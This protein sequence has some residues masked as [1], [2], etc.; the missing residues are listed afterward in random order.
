MALA[1]FFFNF[2]SSFFKSLLA[3]S[4]PSRQRADNELQRM[5]LVSKEKL[6][7]FQA[8]AERRYD[9]DERGRGEGDCQHSL[10][11]SEILI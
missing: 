10:P 5:T 6:G 7:Q 9:S 3:L 2:F 11:C 4:I 8:R 1:F